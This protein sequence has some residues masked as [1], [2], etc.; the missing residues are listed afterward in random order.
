MRT[1]PWTSVLLVALLSS[2]AFAQ[3]ADGQAPT[4]PSP[5]IDSLPATVASVAAQPRWTDPQPPSAVKGAV[6]G[7]I[8]GVATGVVIGAIYCDGW[9][10]ARAEAGFA[11][12][13][14]GAGAGVGALAGSLDPR[15]QVDAGRRARGIRS[16]AVGRVQRLSIAWRF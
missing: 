15:N 4:K 9:H 11:V 5:L 2:S 13:L 14:G 12:L 16:G 7:L 6:I 1:P 10:C 3:S 8:A